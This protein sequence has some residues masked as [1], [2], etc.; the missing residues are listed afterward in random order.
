MA[1]F[2]DEGLRAILGSAFGLTSAAN[3]LRGPS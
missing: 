2:T 1:Y 3:A